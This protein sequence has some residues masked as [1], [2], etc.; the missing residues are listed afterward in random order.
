[1]DSEKTLSRFRGFSA[2]AK[3]IHCEQVQGQTSESSLASE[4][5][6][7]VSKDGDDDVQRRFCGRSGKRTQRI[8][9]GP[10][11][12]ERIRSVSR[13]RRVSDKA[14]RGPRCVQRTRGI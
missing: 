8:S 5:E 4:K 3:I 6:R 11:E 2:Q 12:S 13:I 9:R 7:H 10:S 14:D 1:M